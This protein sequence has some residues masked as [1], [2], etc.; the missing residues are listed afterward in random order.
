MYL[1]I[2]G[3]QS[4][5]TALVADARGNVLGIGHA[6]ASNHARAPGGRE[7][8]ANAINQSV[9]A[10]LQQAGL[11]NHKTVA[12]YKFTSAYLSLTGEPEDKREIVRELLCADVKL[13]NYCRTFFFI[14][15]KNYFCQRNQF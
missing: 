7:R 2:D 8:L 13:N 12:Q 10:A 15:K 5:T 9:G 11:L 14:I 6:G 4:H 1:G 3:G